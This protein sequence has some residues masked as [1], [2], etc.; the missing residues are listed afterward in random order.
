MNRTRTEQRPQRNG[1]TSPIVRRNGQAFPIAGRQARTDVA[2]NAG[3]AVMRFL[4]RLFPGFRSAE[5]VRHALAGKQEPAGWPRCSREVVVAC[6]EYGDERYRCEIRMATPLLYQWV[7]QRLG[8]MGPDRDSSGDTWVWL[9]AWLARADLLDERPSRIAPAMYAVLCDSIP[10]WV[11]NGQARIY[12]YR[13]AGWIP[14]VNEEE[15]DR[16]R[17]GVW[18]VWT[19]R[20]SCPGGHCLYQERQEMHLQYRRD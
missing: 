14:G 9:A 8:S 6:P 2:S 15:S 5:P 10:D 7:E 18:H 13:C 16:G 12:C 11:R 20:W 19:D 4:E 3:Q 17:D 1:P